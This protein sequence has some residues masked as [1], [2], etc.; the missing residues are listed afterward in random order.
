MAGPTDLAPRTDEI[1]AAIRSVARALA[2]AEAPAEELTGRL[3]ARLAAGGRCFVLG[4]GG[5]ASLS[6]HFVADCFRTPF[7]SQ[8]LSI[9]SQP[10]LLTMLANDYSWER[11]IARCV[12]RVDRDGLVPDLVLSLSTSG[13]ATRSKNLVRAVE[14]GRA[15]GA[16][17]VA[18]VP[19]EG[20][21]LGMA[22][23][24]ACVIPVEDARAEV[25]EAVFLAVLHAIALGLRSR[26]S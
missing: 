19:Y 26:T 16:T 10:T 3:H 23:N 6:D 25:I 12:D 21:P 13:A 11:E 20:T 5:C 9:A 2:S 22:S 18:V 8:V 1:G 24:Y 15:L 4:N 14:A 7:A 17:T